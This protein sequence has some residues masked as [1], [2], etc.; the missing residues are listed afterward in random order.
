[1]V[2]TIDGSA[3]SKIVCVNSM[4]FLKISKSERRFRDQT[5]SERPTDWEMSRIRRGATSSYMKSVVT[6][7]RVSTLKEY[8]PEVPKKIAGIAFICLNPELNFFHLKS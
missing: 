7:V 5:A 8:S 1:M 3:F 6:L 2:K 4:E